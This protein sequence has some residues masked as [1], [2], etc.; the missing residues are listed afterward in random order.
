MNQLVKKIDKKKSCFDQQKEQ[1]QGRSIITKYDCFKI[2]PTL[3]FSN[4]C[5]KKI[6]VLNTFV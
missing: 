3:R 5:L 4:N 1:Q 2:F 6:L